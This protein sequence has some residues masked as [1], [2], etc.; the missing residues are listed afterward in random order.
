MAK[1]YMGPKGPFCTFTVDNQRRKFQ[2]TKYSE[3]VARKITSH[4]EVL[5]VAQKTGTGVPYGTVEWLEKI[6]DVLRN[7]L[8]SA[9]LCGSFARITLEQLIEEF[10]LDRKRHVVPRTYDVWVRHAKELIE[11][12]GGHVL[13]RTVSESQLL[14]ERDRLVEQFAEGTVHKRLQQ[15]KAIFEFAQGKGYI[16]NN[17]VEWFKGR[18]S[19]AASKTYVTE[20]RIEEVIAATSSLEWKRL[21]SLS[22]YAGIRVPS[23]FRRMTWSDIDR[24]QKWVTIYSPK[25][26]RHSRGESRRCPWFKELQ[27]DFWNQPASAKG[28]D[29]V[30]PRLRRVRTMFNAT[31]QL[32]STVGLESWTKFYNSNRSSRITDLLEVASIQNVAKWVGNS[33]KVILSN[34]AQ[35][36]DSEAARLV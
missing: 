28:T 14:D 29:F 10:L 21:L 1:F 32:F 24:D 3:E 30:F 27:R 13:L 31:E 15:W 8:E 35:A 11:Q 33:P 23:E 4:V 6:D 12:L 17:P 25:T 34:Y 5:E 7:R 36:L 18:S 9:G 26:K 19:E 16:A 20:E 2:L 22:R